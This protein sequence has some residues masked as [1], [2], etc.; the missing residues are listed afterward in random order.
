MAEEFGG[1]GGAFEGDVVAAGLLEVV[2]ELDAGWSGSDDDV[3]VVFGGG[4]VVARRAWGGCRHARDLRRCGGL[5]STLGGVTVTRP[6]VS[7]VASPAV[8]AVSRG[9]PGGGG[10]RRWWTGGVYGGDG[11]QL[12]EAVAVGEDVVELDAGLPGGVGGAAAEGVPAGEESG[13][14]GGQVEVAEE[15]PWGGQGAQCADGLAEL[16]GVPAGDEGQV[17]GGDGEPSVWGVEDGGEDDAG[18][19][20]QEDES[21]AGP[22][23]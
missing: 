9:R 16:V 17:G 6:L 18:F 23:T 20:A 12:V 13:G 4:V 22:G 19:V 1:C 8:C 10:G 2:A 5:V 11:W 14:A 3:P 21:A 7:G 15:D